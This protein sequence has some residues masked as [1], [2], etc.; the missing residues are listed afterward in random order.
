M[1]DFPRTPVSAN[2]AASMSGHDVLKRLR[3]RLRRRRGEDLGL[4][5]RAGDAHYR[6]FVGPP[7]EYDLIAAMTFNLLTTVGLRQHHRLLD[8]GCGSLRVGRL[9]IP[10]L[11]RG[12]Y[13]GVEPNRWLVEEAIARE[14]GGTLV[15]L[16]RPEFVFADSLEG[17]GWVERF[18]FAVAQSIFSH[19]GVALLRRWLRE[20]SAAL[21]ADGA[22]LATFLP[23]E[24]DSPEEGWTYPACVRFRPATVRELAAA[25][26]LDCVLLDWFHPR[27]QWA[28][29]AKPQF[30]AG[31]F[32]ENPLTWS[33]R[34]PLLL[35]RER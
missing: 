20:T 4:S 28:L 18:D 32:R 3:K 21:R 16:K 17:T 15:R 10:Y 25:H 29:L 9:L 27:Q 13:A 11:N 7:A 31:W 35:A 26:G 12:G 8:I 22:L 19:T 30:D 14:I 34:A 6:A 2:E 1:P 5:S 23:A 24:T 33:A